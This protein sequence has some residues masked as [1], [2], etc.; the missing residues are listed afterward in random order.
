MIIADFDFNGT[1]VKTNLTAPVADL[2]MAVGE[3]ARAWYIDAPTFEPVILGDWKGSVAL[4]GSVNF[5]NV[6]FNPHAHGTHTE[7]VGH[8]TEERYSVHKHFNQPFTLAV[9]LSPQVVDDFVSMEAFETAWQKASASGWLAGVKSIIIRTDCASDAVLRNYSNTD[10]PF[11]DAEIG[12]FLRAQGI[13]HILIDQPSV[14]QEEDG[15]ALACH[16]SFWGPTP[17]ESLHRTITELIHVPSTL[18][19]GPYVLNLQVAPIE[20]DA[21]PSRPLL[22]ELL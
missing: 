19:D 20:N 14:D 21:A 22:Y 12:S 16:R 4:G 13:D 10:W 17:E 5:F 3:V 2:S 15:G 18:E 7:T 9:M 6:G 8:I 11:L 1:R